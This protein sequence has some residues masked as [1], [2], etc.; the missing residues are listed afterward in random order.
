MSGKAICT[1]SARDLRRGCA[2]YVDNYYTESVGQW[3]ANDQQGDYT[4]NPACPDCLST[5]I[6]V[7][8]AGFLSR[9]DPLLTGAMKRY[10][11]PSPGAGL[12]TTAALLL[13]RSFLRLDAKSHLG[14][15]GN[16]RGNDYA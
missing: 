16:A 1:D 10:P 3:V 8:R 14:G 12:G 5:V 2:L 13:G 11:L 7:G 15:E 6:S 9:A 4:H